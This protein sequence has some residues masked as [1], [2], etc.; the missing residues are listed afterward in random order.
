MGVVGSG[1]F[2]N[3]FPNAESELCFWRP[4]DLTGNPTRHRSC[5]CS[6][7]SLGC[8]A[9]CRSASECN[10]LLLSHQ[11]RELLEGAVAT[12]ISLW[13]CVDHGDSVVC[14]LPILRF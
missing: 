5:F 6:E 9:G 7:R 10:L 2:G 8:G 12:K 4:V 14:R 3:S 1:S 13:A 11:P